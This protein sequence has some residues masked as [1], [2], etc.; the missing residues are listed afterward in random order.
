MI[1]TALPS[2]ETVAFKYYQ[3]VSDNTQL[4]KN[5]LYMHVERIMDFKETTCFMQTV[6]T[7]LLYSR[8][9]FIYCVVLVSKKY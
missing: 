9:T 8:E 7:K 1:C 5:K 3:G 2:L 6:T 4:L